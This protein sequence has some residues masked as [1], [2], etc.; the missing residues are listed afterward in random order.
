MEISDVRET[1]IPEL[2]LFCGRPIIMADDVGEKPTGSHATYK[3]TL[4]YGRG[5]GRPEEIPEPTPEGLQMKRIEEYRAT[6]SFTAY[7]MDEIESYEL[8]QKIH[9][10]FS[11]EGYNF[12][13]QFGIAVA[14]QTDITNRDAFIVENYERRNGFDV[15]LRIMRTR[16]QNVD[17]FDKV[18]MKNRVTGGIFSE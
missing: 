18:A 2:T 8:A 11:F 4:P 6:F 5:I 15:I 17:W 3:I 7:S 16:R 10:W 14:E 12:L 9:D 1:I 13:N